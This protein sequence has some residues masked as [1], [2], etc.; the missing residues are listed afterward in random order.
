MINLIQNATNY[1]ERIAVK[2]EGEPY[3][4][5]QLLDASENI[6]L[7]LLDGKTNLDEAR[8]AFLVPSGFDYVAIQWGIWRAGGI[9]VPLCDKHPLASIKYV[10]ED[11]KAS[12]V[13][14][15]SEFASLLSP[16]RSMTEARF[17]S[18]EKFST[19][20]GVLPDVN[21]SQRAMILY[22]SGTTGNPKGVD[23]T[24]KYRSTDYFFDYL[25][26]MEPK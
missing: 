25:M 5:Q 3:T 26:A 24:S 10:I 11:T 9:A 14:F 16:L 18:S 23:H 22:T 20:E 19:K 13:I 17:L 15:S 12:I 6:A 21:P 1:S 2:S 8:V 7:E 4:Y